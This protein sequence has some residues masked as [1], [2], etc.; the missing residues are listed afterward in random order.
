MTDE[1]RARQLI[2]GVLF[3]DPKRDWTCRELAS[4]LRLTGRTIAREVRHLREDDKIERTY[5]KRR[6]MTFKA[7]PEIAYPRWMDPVRMCDL[8]VIAVVRVVFH[9][10]DE[11][12]Q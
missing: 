5:G 2:E 12:D 6:R 4:L 3:E 8:K 1:T 10:I 9:T 11:D 7:K